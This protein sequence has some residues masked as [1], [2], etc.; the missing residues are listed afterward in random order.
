MAEEKQ[1]EGTSLLNLYKSDEYNYLV[2]ECRAIVIQRLKNSRTELIIG[3]GELGQRIFNDPLYKKYG[4]GNRSLLVNLFLDAGIREKTGYKAIQF[5][6]K[7]IHEKFKDVS[8]AL[9]SLF[10]NEGD[11]L[12]WNK[13]CNKYLPEPREKEKEETEV[14]CQHSKVRCLKCGKELS[15]EELL[16]ARAKD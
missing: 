3:Y 15:L 5:Y 7:F 8:H 2:E 14:E 9:E 16:K 6:E 10:P 4:K 1:L 12:S 11:N 13:V